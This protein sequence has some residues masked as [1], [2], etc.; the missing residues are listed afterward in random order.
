MSQTIKIQVCPGS[1]QEIPLDQVNEDESWGVC[2]CCKEPELVTQDLNGSWLPQ[3]HLIKVLEGGGFQRE[4]RM[5][6]PAR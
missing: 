4:V 5:Y 1:A 2:I 6:P 3:R